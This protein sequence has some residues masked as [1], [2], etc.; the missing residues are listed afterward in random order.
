MSWTLN[1]KLCQARCTLMI[2]LDLNATEEHQ[3]VTLSEGTHS[4]YL[5][6]VYKPL[7]AIYTKE[8]KDAQ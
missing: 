3:M 4:S 8:N 5:N 1:T 6:V 7:S 2:A